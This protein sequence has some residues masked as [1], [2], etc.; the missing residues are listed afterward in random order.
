MYRG[1]GDPLQALREISDPAWPIY[2]DWRCANSPFEGHCVSTVNGWF[3]RLCGNY[4]AKVSRAGASA[5]ARAQVQLALGEGG[6]LVRKYN[7]NTEGMDKEVV[8]FDDFVESIST[9]FRAPPTTLYFKTEQQ[10][11]R[12][13]MF[14]LFLG[15]SGMRPGAFVDNSRG[16]EERRPADEVGE[17]DA[18]VSIQNLPRYKDCKLTQFPA[19]DGGRHGDWVLELQVRH[20]KG[21]VKS[22]EKP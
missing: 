6:W 20:V 12:T 16:Q 11:A 13:W 22:G 17:F 19:E 10:R 7:L 14:E 4:L 2:L 15:C 18:V 5:Q 9:L 1:Y 8:N 21:G 3:K